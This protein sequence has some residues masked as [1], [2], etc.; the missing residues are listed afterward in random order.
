MTVWPGAQRET[1]L[2]RDPLTESRCSPAVTT[3][4]LM[5]RIP[6]K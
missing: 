4:L 1:A 6:I 2:L 3:D 5:I